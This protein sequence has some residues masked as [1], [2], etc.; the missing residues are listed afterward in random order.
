MV[1]DAELRGQLGQRVRKIAVAV[2][3]QAQRELL[4]GERHRAE[5]DVQA[6]PLGERAVVH[7]RERTVRA[8]P[9]DRRAINRRIG[10]VHQDA[11][12]VAGTPR[13]SSVRRQVS[14]TVITRSANDAASF[15][16]QRDQPDRERRQG[17]SET[18]R[19]E[20]RHEVVEI[21]DHLHAG[22]LQQ[23]SREDQEIRR[24]VDLDRAVVA[25]SVAARGV[26]HGQC[27]KGQVLEELERRTAAPPPPD[28]QALHLDAGKLRVGGV[29]GVAGAEHV[30]LDPIGDECA[31]LAFDARIRPM[32][33]DDHQ[34]AMC[35]LPMR[36]RCH[37][38]SRGTP[39]IP[40]GWTD[41]FVPRDNATRRHRT[42]AAPGGLGR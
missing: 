22:E 40:A 7:E 34:V 16:C 39:T 32:V 25:S 9:R 2:D 28:R 18:A 36:A 20:L 4:P 6:V 1:R 26:E 17:P 42:V 14:V 30:D 41:C 23:Q 27:Q 38:P 21:Q 37:V 33:V 24:G 13:V 5:R 12:L 11:E 10:Q 8:R 3:D 31:R 15:S 35:A 29:V 19:V